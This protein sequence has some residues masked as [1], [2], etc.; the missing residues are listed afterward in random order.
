MARKLGARRRSLG[1]EFDGFSGCIRCICCI[2]QDL[3]LRG[4]WQSMEVENK[5][6]LKQ[7]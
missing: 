5:A 1:L 4:S 2:V 7:T 3:R 6:I